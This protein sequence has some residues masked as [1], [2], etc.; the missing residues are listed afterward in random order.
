LNGLA[1]TFGLDATP[2][3]IEVYDNSHIMGTNAVGAMIV[4]GAGRI[5]EEPV[6]Q[7]QHPLEGDHAGRR[8]RHDARG[9]AAAFLA[10]D[11]GG[12]TPK[13]EP[14]G[15]RTIADDARFRNGLTSS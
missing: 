13:R 4:A 1:E 8:F 10:P 3:R 11:Q 2:R 6:P 9:D 15:P 12:T 7:V 14:S 5:R